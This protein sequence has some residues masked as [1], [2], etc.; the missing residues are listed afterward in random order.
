MGHESQ[1]AREFVGVLRSALLWLSPLSWLWRPSDVSTGLIC[2]LSPLFYSR[3]RWVALL[4]GLSRLRGLP[5]SRPGELAEVFVGRQFFK[6]RDNLVQLASGNV[7]VNL[8]DHK[9]DVPKTRQGHQALNFLA[10]SRKLPR[11]GSPPR[12]RRRTS[13]AT[14]WREEVDSHPN[15]A[16]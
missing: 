5:R 13:Q 3:R 2:N 15:E 6:L 7:Y 14:L 12:S 4:G 1:L 11:T 9:F 16:F 8:S 10:V